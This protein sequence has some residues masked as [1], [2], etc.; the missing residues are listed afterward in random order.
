MNN[1]KTISLRVSG[2]ER[3]INADC[4]NFFQIRQYNSLYYPSHQRASRKWRD[5]HVLSGSL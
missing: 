4:V 2:F 1:E 5:G 3:I